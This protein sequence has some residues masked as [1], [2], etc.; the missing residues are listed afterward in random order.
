[1]KYTYFIPLAAAAALLSLYFDFALTFVQADLLKGATALEFGIFTLQCC[2]II[3]IIS[4]KRLR[5]AQFTNIVNI[6][7][8][9]LVVLLPGLFIAYV[10]FGV[11]NVP[12]LVNQ[13]FL[14]WIAGA[15]TFGT[16]YAGYRLARAMTQGETLVTILPSTIFLSELL[17][18]MVAGANSAASS[19]SGFTGLVRAM[20]QA[21]AGVAG[22]S[23]LAVEETALLPLAVLYVS[24]LLYALVPGWD[25]RYARF[26]NLAALALLATAVTCAGVYASSLMAV[27]MVYLVIPASLITV[28]LV[29]WVTREV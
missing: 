16:P 7:G 18:L 10:Y 19:G 17:V 1:M 13:L 2:K 24:L 11:Q 29:W 20:L 8:A 3:T 4:V 6:L 26:R 22:V 27:A 28:T 15:T 9:E 21:A 23:A 14:A 12:S 5:H 25:E